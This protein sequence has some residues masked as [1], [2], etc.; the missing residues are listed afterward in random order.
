MC[1]CQWET[2]MKTMLLYF[3]PK[4]CVLDRE[5]CAAGA[6][7][8]NEGVP[9]PPPEWQ[10]EPKH[11]AWEGKETHSCLK[12]KWPGHYMTCLTAITLYPLLSDVKKI[13]LNTQ[14]SV[15]SYFEHETFPT[16]STMFSK[17]PKSK[18]H[19]ELLFR[20]WCG[21]FDCPVRSHTP[22]PN[23]HLPP[24][25]TSDSKGHL[26][27]P[28]ISEINRESSNYIWRPHLWK[29]ELYPSYTNSEPV[30]D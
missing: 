20:T 19:K 8:K 9:R 26:P 5:T 22:L 4:V 29:F 17:S 24:P 6:G 18:T 1:Y 12:Q 11:T 27:P 23:T 3:F 25:V 13:T 28:L 30:S 7:G 16:L 2:T 15:F 10:E 14:T 21:S